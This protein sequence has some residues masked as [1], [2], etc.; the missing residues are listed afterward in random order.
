MRLLEGK[1]ALIVG[2]ANAQ[3]IAWNIAKAFHA[4]GA[5]LAFT[6]VGGTMRRV[7]KL[8]PEV[9]SDIVLPC[10]V[11]K[12]DEIASAVGQVGALWD[13]K[14]DILVHSVAYA[15]LDDMG[16]EFIGVSREGWALALDVS[17]YSLIALTRAA[18]PLMRAAGGGSV[19]TLTFSASQRVVPGYNI[20][21]VAKAALECSVRYLAYDLG[22]ENIRVNALSPGP[23][24]T[25][26]SSVV[27]GFESAERLVAEHSP[28]LR[29]ATVE[30]IGDSAVYLASS[31]SSAVTGDVLYVAAGMN[32]MASPSI[33]HRRTKPLTGTQA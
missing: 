16:G 7:K 9:N 15:N 12:D 29:N 11:R 4:Q 25:M 26:S 10:D 20:M 32:S 17:A 13:G 5:Q 3:S 21:A 2:V 8:A 19:F 18:R 24:R 28:L 6:C 27:E 31:L 22:P 30:E 33:P 14:L 1:K 23:V